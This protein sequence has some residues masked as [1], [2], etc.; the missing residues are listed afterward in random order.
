MTHAITYLPQ[1]NHII[2]L[3]NGETSETGNYSDLL[4]KK[5]AFAEF[6][7]QHITEEV[8]DVDELEELATQLADTPIAVEFTRTISRQRSRLSESGSIGSQTNLNELSRTESRESLR[9]R[10]STSVR[11]IS[12]VTRRSSVKVPQEKSKSCLL[13]SPVHLKCFFFLTSYC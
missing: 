13:E 3:T 12:G 5:G 11:K 7:M 2:C 6:I 8:E 9:R 1:T 4:A 10:P